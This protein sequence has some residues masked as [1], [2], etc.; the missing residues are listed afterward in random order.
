MSLKVQRII[1]YRKLIMQQCA[2][3]YIGILLHIHHYYFNM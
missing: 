1:Y 3:W 2:Y